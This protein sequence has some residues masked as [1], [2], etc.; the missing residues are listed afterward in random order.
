MTNKERAEVA[1]ATHITGNCESSEKT[2]PP[3]LEVASGLAN[4][5]GN[6]ELYGRVLVKF[7]TNSREQRDRLVKAWHSND[8]ETMFHAV[9]NI[10]SS[11]AAIGGLKA[12]SLAAEVEKM[13]RGASDEQLTGKVEMMV[14]A[15]NE[16]L[17]F[18]EVYH[19]K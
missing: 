6:R 13:I 12:S 16:L 1:G 15:V 4:L 19:G 3:V 18:V 11:S 5:A 10:K 8:R 7:M 17:D 14:A 9:H 2:V